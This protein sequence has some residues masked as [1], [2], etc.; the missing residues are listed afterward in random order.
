M[1][2]NLLRWLNKNKKQEVESDNKIP[3]L[4]KN[5]RKNNKRSLLEHVQVFFGLKL[6][7]AFYPGNFFWS[8]R[9]ALRY[10]QT[11][12][13][14][15][16]IWCPSQ[17]EKEYKYGKYTVTAYARWRWSDPWTGNFIVYDNSAKY[18]LTEEKYNRYTGVWSVEVLHSYNFTD[19]TPVRE[20]ERAL[21][22]E[23]KK[24]FV[25]KS[26]VLRFER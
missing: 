9:E 19:E 10:E 7:D 22:R 26:E 15:D 3:N 11:G 18:R 6:P 4:F 8:L 17:L 5:F 12:W 2:A 25:D 14:R 16:L 24:Y 1:L 20:V 13:T 23:Y 21:E